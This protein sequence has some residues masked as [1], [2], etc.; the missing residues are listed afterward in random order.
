MPNVFSAEWWS[1]IGLIL[2]A[3]AFALLSADLVR[4]MRGER[5][6]RDEIQQLERTQFSWRYGFLAPSK[7]IQDAQQ[8][9]FDER[10]AER[11]RKSEQDMNSRRRLAYFAIFLAVLGLGMQMYGG[12]PG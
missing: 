4:S 11:R 3:V 2:D 5:L 7:E 12:W 10:Q 1:E 9:E 8:R 6:A